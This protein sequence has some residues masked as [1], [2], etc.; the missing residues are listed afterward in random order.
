[1]NL[2]HVLLTGALVVVALLGGFYLY[3]RWT[4]RSL[5]PEE[6]GFPYV[7]VNNRGRARE[8]CAEEREYL[9][10]K[11]EPFDGARPALVFRYE[12]LDASEFRSGFIERRFLPPQVDIIKLTPE[13]ELRTRNDKI[14]IN[15]AVF[16]DR[17]PPSR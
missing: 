5:R 16:E 14:S 1:M 17:C 3:L 11:F 13:D 12:K 2:F 7:W 6:P 15:Q 8:L 9:N 4:F 10:Q